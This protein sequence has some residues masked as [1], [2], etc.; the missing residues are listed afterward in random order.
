[1]TRNGLE[2]KFPSAVS[3]GNLGIFSVQIGFNFSEQSVASILGQKE[4]HSVPSQK[5]RASF[6]TS[7]CVVYRLVNDSVCRSDNKASNELCKLITALNFE[8]KNWGKLRRT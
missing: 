5:T 6:V 3:L 7:V 8:L 4:L 2:S 1:V